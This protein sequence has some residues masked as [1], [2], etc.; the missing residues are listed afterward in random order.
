MHPYARW[1]HEDWLRH[2]AGPRLNPAT[3]EKG[4]VWDPLGR[5]LPGVA[6]QYATGLRLLYPWGDD[7]PQEKIR[8]DGRFKSVLGDVASCQTLSPAERQAFQALYDTWRRFFC[9][10]ASVNCSKPDWSH[11]ALGSQMDQIEKWEARL[12]EW[13]QKLQ[14]RCALSA[15]ANKPQT[16]YDRER[17]GL[18][19][20]K[21]IAKYGAI[22]A[23]YL[24]GPAA[25]GVGSRIAS[26]REATE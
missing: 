24:L 12:F 10:S 23:A 9:N 18:G 13:Q 15:P 5:R 26:R 6:Q 7:I 21:D 3:A 19:N 14:G 25:R 17:E 16:E 1:S 4:S 8:V 11:F 22:A 20:M 2:Y